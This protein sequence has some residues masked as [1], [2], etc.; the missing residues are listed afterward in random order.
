MDIHSLFIPTNTSKWE[1]GYIAV[2]QLR[3]VSIERMGHCIRGS[4]F[5]HVEISDRTNDNPDLYNNTHRGHCK[6]RIIEPNEQ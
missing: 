5:S 1:I 6:W 4:R 2:S 3:R